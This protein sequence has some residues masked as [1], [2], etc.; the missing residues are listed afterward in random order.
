M[1]A[2]DAEVRQAY[3]AAWESSALADLSGWGKIVFRGEDRAEFLQGLVSCDV[4]AL[5][6]GQGGPG[7][8]LTPKGKLAADFWLVNRGADFLAWASPASAE[9]LQHSLSKYLALSATRMEELS[10]SWTGL[11]L[12]GPKALEALGSALGAPCGAAQSGFAEAAL[13]GLRL[14]IFHYPRLHPQGYVLLAGGGAQEPLLG[15]LKKAGVLCSLTASREA[16]EMIRVERAAGLY[17]VD[18]STEHFPYEAGLEEAVCLSKGCYLGQEFMA[19]IKNFGHVNRRLV[20]LKIKGEVPVGAPVFSGCQEVGRITSC[21]P[22]IR[23][24][25]FLG[26][27]MLPVKTFDSGGPLE[28]RGTAAEPARALTEPV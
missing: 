14:G 24:G 12:M 1:S 4:S 17:G 25:D 13:D 20:R 6:P 23:F 22:S 8:L 7:C 11:Y 18:M 15:A 26:L 28:V 21:G 19:R 9:S 16:L 3:E 27:A 10:G 2:G 5:G